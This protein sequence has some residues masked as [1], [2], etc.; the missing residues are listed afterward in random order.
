MQRV[1]KFRA[2][3]IP[4]KKMRYKMTPEEWQIANDSKH[5]EL[6]QYTGLLD[7]NGV[8]IYEGDIVRGLEFD[9]ATEKWIPGEEVTDV[10]WT[11]SYKPGFYFPQMCEVI[12]NRFENS[13]LLK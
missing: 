12:G 13:E 4:Q 9:E 8:E 1:I 5:F 6:M 7:E 2:W 10:K 11:N 3:D